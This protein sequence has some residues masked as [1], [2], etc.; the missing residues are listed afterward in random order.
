MDRHGV[1][2]GANERACALLALAAE[3]LV[4][5]PLRTLYRA[6]SRHRI[7]AWLGRAGQGPG[8]EFDG[9]L[10]RNDQRSVPIRVRASALDAAGGLSLHCLQPREPYEQLDD[11]FE[12][13]A[14]RFR[15]FL[16]IVDVWI[17]GVAPALAALLHSNR[18]YGEV[19]GGTLTEL[20]AD[21]QTL[22]GYVHEGDLERAR[23]LFGIDAQPA[24]REC[25]LRIVHPSRGART[26]RVR[27][28]PVGHEDG[29]DWLYGTAEDVTQ[30]RALERAR[31]EHVMQQ[32]DVLVR[33]VHHRIKNTLQ[34]VAGLL[35]QGAARRPEVASLVDEVA[36]Q[37]Q[38][39]AQVHGLQVAAD[40][41]LALQDVARAVFDSLGRNF[42]LAFGM[43]EDTIDVAAPWLLS[44]QEAVPLALVVNE[45]GTNAIKHG[46]AAERGQARVGARLSSRAQG[47]RIEIW[48][49]GSLPERFSFEAAPPSP[50]GLGLIKS[51]LPRR[52][53]RLR[54]ERH[55]GRVCAVLELQPPAI[56]PGTAQRAES[57]AG[58]G[59]AG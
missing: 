45:L 47:A 32:R 10:L 41:L 43:Q 39:I 35:R 13:A 22:L 12:H 28:F 1:V 33:E 18:R 8:D 19:W 52:G 56:T 15:R 59:A 53:A 24:A 29:N 57:L 25:D 26:V 14:A 48:N 30:V 27:V 16:D 4:G 2:A 38:A 6:D 17:F 11:A 34:G 40:G 9:W 42:G 51:L 31:I 49:E 21:P 36:G 23:V 50:S 3:T 54:F 58:G 55:D 20:Q 44:E 5:S 37:I 7:D 46:L